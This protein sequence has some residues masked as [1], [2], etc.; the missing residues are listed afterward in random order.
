MQLDLHLSNKVTYVNQ[1]WR[2]LEAADIKQTQ[3][4]VSFLQKEF[5]V[6]FALTSRVKGK[7]ISKVWERSNTTLKED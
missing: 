4:M 7:L 3:P 1:A 5:L 6:N 2:W